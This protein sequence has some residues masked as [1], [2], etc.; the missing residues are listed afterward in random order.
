M[1]LYLYLIKIC[2]VVIAALLMNKNYP[3]LKG[4][5]QTKEIINTR[6]KNVCCCRNIQ[7]KN[8]IIMRSEENN[9]RY[10]RIRENILVTYF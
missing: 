4:C 3:C 1:L 5:S 2:N 10:S 8:E 6:Y 7:M 9:F